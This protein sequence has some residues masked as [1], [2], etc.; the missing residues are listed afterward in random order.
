MV[1]DIQGVEYTLCDPEVTGSEL[2]DPDDNSFRFC[3]GNL[4]FQAIDRSWVVMFATL[5][6]DAKAFNLID[7]SDH[8]LK[9]SCSAASICVCTHVVFTK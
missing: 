9:R 8:I 7:A 3:T 5:L 1:L 2:K 4:S 6:Q